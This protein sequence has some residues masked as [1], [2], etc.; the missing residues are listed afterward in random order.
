MPFA[1]YLYISEFLLESEVAPDLHISCCSSSSIPTWANDG[2]RFKC[3]GRWQIA[4]LQMSLN[5]FD[6]TR[7]GQD[8]TIDNC[9]GH[10]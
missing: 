4:E 2:K 7:T 6:M 9:D 5:L 1:M 8:V 10:E 3:A